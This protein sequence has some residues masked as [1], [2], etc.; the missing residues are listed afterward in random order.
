MSNVITW[1][2]EFWQREIR[3]KVDEESAMGMSRLY[4]IKREA[5]NS[6]VVNSAG[7]L[8]RFDKL[9]DAAA[10][11]GVEWQTV[12]AIMIRKKTDIVLVN[13]H[14]DGKINIQ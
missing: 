7:F 3:H 4:V 1:A 10:V 5:G 9:S 13:V 8:G 14:R 2:I 6:F 12:E 11:A